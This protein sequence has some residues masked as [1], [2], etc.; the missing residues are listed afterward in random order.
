VLSVLHSAD[1]GK[2][3]SVRAA[4]AAR[5]GTSARRRTSPWTVAF[6]LGP[7]LVGLSAF[8]LYPLVKTVYYGFTDFDGVTA[9]HWVGFGN[10]ATIFG[11]DPQFRTAVGNTAWWVL[12]S[13]PLSMVVAFL[14]AVLLASKVRGVGVFRTII[15]LPSM[16]P[17]AGSTLLFLWLLNPAGGV[18]NNLSAAAG[19]PTLGW[20]TSPT[21]AKPALLLQAL[22]SVGAMMIIFLAGLQQIPSDRYEAATIDGAGIWRRTWHVTLPGLIPVIFFNLILSLVGAFTYFGPPLIA[23]SAPGGLGGGGAA[24]GVVGNPAGSTL[25]LS[26]YIYEQLFTQYRFGY[27]AALS[28]ILAAAVVV[29][30]GVLF[31]VGRRLTMG[32]QE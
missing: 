5:R 7:W 9:E 27:A 2:R 15:Y 23:S 22:W 25:T 12:I 11:S 21:W 8:Y 17:T 26:V 28:S 16:I 3:A 29:L 4:S 20:F 32:T 6:F 24:T 18:V 31:L 13:V 19:G 14:L 1:P 30:A 10:F